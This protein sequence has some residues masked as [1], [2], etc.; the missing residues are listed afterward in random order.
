MALS[1]FL[2][3]A[4]A[5][6]IAAPL[7]TLKTRSQANAQK[8]SEGVALT[9]LHPQR[10]TGYWVGCGPLVIRGA[11]LTSGQLLGYDATK[12]LA[13]SQGLP[14][15]PAVH[16]GAAIV[17]GFLAATFSAPADVLM[18][19]LQS[20]LPAQGARR[21]GLVPL[22]QMIWRDEGVRGFGRGWSVNVLR[23]AP[24]TV[25]GSLIVEQVRSLLGVGYLR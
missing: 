7:W 1:G 16:V 2:T 17:A 10:L 20:S 14:E 13:R 4:L 22:A 6:F 23:L 24:T 15:G 18:T 21:T 9:P 19:R 25:I 11:L 3:G 5:Y 8:A 12:R